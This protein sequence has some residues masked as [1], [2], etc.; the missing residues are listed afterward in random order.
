VLKASLNSTKIKL[1]LF[2]VLNKTDHEIIWSKDNNTNYKSLYMFQV[3]LMFYL[4]EQLPE[5]QY[6][7]E[8][9]IDEEQHR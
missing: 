3:N 9:L 2:L 6:I 1:I 7:F 8:I 5:I 4:Y